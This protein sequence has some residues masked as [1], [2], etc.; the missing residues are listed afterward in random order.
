[1]TLLS[2]MLEL[3]LSWDPEVL[4]E[5]GAEID[6]ARSSL[7]MSWVKLPQAAAARSHPVG[8]QY[9]SRI[10]ASATKF[11]GERFERWVDRIVGGHLSSALLGGWVCQCHLRVKQR[12]LLANDPAK[13]R[14]SDLPS[15]DHF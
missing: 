13:S 7:R 9:T 14:I 15:F 3:N 10:V 4:A 5:L 6:L 11:P 8:R 2:R 1:M 12:C